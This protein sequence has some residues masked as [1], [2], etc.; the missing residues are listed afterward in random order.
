MPITFRHGASV[1]NRASFRRLPIASWFGQ[2]RSANPRLTMTTSGAAWSS[3][4][5]KRRPAC[6]RIPIA[7]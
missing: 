5:V 2:Y 4:S 6:R 7:A 3:A 1:S